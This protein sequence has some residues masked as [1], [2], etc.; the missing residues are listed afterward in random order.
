[1]HNNYTFSNSY[2]SKK[3]ALKRIRRLIRI[4]IIA[5]VKQMRPKSKVTYK[6]LYG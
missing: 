2:I 4:D 1:M 5:A 6:M 3:E